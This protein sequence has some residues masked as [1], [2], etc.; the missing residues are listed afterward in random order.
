[1]VQ[2]SPET[3][4]GENPLP[5]DRSPAVAMGISP[6]D[7]EA[8]TEDSIAAPAGEGAPD[9]T[10]PGQVDPAHPAKSVPPGFAVPPPIG[11]DTQQVLE[12][13]P[14]EAN[15]PPPVDLNWQSQKN[16]KTR[17]IALAVAVGLA[18]I[19]SLVLL[20]PVVIRSLREPETV[21]VNPDLPPP[22]GIDDDE[23][24]DP[25][26]GENRGSDPSSDPGSEIPSLDG[27]HSGDAIESDSG[28]NP[29]RSSETDND[30]SDNPVVTPNAELGPAEIPTPPGDLL[31]GNP[32]GDLMLGGPTQEPGDQ[33]GDQ[34]PDAPTMMELPGDLSALLDDINFQRSHMDASQPAPPTVEDITL[35]RAA[36]DPT[37]GRV[38]VAQPDSINTRKSLGLTVAVKSASPEGYPLGDMMLLLS[39]L[40]S[41]PIEFQWVSFELVGVE[42]QQRI[43]PL[44]DWPTIEERLNAICEKINA[45][46]EATAT[47]I[48]LR[49]KPE[50]LEQTIETM[51]D[52]SD[53]PNES[54]SAAATAR[55]LLGQPAAKI[56]NA[57]LETP[58]AEGQQ[59]LAVLVAESMRRIRGR[60]GMM[61]DPAFSRWSGPYSV[62]INAWKQLSGGISGPALVSPESIAGLMRGLARRNGA[63]CF[64]NWPDLAK[65]DI[66]P[67]DRRMP[68]CGDQVSAAS[69][70]EQIFPSGKLQVRQVDSDHWWLGT[71]GSFDRFPVVVWF[72]KTSDAVAVQKKLAKVLAK[73]RNAIQTPMA[74]T[75]DPLSGT[76]VSVMPRF[77]LQQ[78]PGLLQ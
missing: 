73:A 18:T 50:L 33:T 60:P 31:P 46:F 12:G 49:P 36:E 61:K 52:L 66:T 4:P 65:R 16:A 78:L 15:A 71:Q 32:L 48:V 29:S 54:E 17:R 20:V 67:V 44:A 51:L 26:A 9:A 14:T 40:S 58:A 21:G 59:Q 53:L 34:P 64:V 6:V 63:V 25:N 8:L 38:N 27:L 69:V 24:L 43:Q 42:L 47:S 1:M 70:V 19:L 2:L 57:R 30:S 68:F 39:Q 62:Q 45:E 76:C 75:I 7:S 74:V 55:V 35:E 28:E 5:A 37:L 72:D 23:G 22:E 13:Q 41:V 10:Y 11:E 3:K 77:L 56:A